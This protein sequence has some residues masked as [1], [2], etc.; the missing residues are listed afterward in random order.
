ML[1]VLLACQRLKTIETHSIQALMKPN[2]NLMDM[3]DMEKM[4]SKD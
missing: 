1:E 2:T 4:N 3:L